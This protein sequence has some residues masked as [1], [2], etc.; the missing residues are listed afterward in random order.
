[1]TRKEAIIDIR[2]NIKPVVGGKSLDMAIEALKFQSEYEESQKCKTCKFYGHALDEKVGTDVCYGCVDN[3]YYRPKESEKMTREKIIKGL[4]IISHDNNCLYTPKYGVMT[5]K[6]VCKGAIEAL[7]Q[8]KEGEWII[9]V[10]DGYTDCKCSNCNSDGYHKW[11]YCQWCG[12]KMK[13][14]D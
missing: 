12:A 1:M 4:E 11:H 7:N 2:D 13:E 10:D 14:G 8:Q 6:L 9:G 3:Q 5:V